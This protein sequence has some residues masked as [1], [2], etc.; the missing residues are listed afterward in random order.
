MFCQ[1]PGCS[2]PVEHCDGLITQQA[3]FYAHRRLC[4]LQH[5]SAACRQNRPSQSVTNIL[6]AG[7]KHHT[8]DPRPEHGTAAHSA[9]FTA[10]KYDCSMQTLWAEPLRSLSYENHFGMGCAVTRAVLPVG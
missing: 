7:C 8:F 4:R 10:G 2:A 9:G 3:F 6:R 1:T 5:L